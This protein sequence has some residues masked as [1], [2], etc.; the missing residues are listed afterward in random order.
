M[1]ILTRDLK[2]PTVLIG[3]INKTLNCCFFSIELKLSYINLKI[4]S[5][6]A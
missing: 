4:R 3:Q 5:I 1:E 2:V 6:L